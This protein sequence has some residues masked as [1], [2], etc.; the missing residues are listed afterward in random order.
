MNALKTVSLCADDFGLNQGISQSILKLAAR[1][2]LS[3]VSCMV[4]HPDFLLHAPELL[5]HRS[6]VQIGL[7]FN[8][9]QGNLISQSDKT[10]FSLNYLLVK[11]HLR[12]IDKR[13]IAKEFLVQLNRF[14]EVMGFL[15]DFIDGHQHV[16]QFPGIRKVVLDI[17][18]KHLR[19]NNSAIRATYPAVSIEPYLLKSR[20]LELT[21]G[22]ALMKSL[23]RRAIPHNDY[24]SGIYDFKKGSDYRSLFRQWLKLAPDNTMIMCHPGDGGDVSDSIAHARP[25]ELAYLLSEDFVMDCEEF[26]V[27]INDKPKSAT[28]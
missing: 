17:Y 24:F 15:P 16:H 9:T 22:K 7:H 28:V 10:A 2:R 5:K 19:Q 25:S 3:A 12:M 11:S 14:Q 26:G 21:G 13:L 20:V 18:E 27:K 8:L 4:T 23:K 6:K 1:G